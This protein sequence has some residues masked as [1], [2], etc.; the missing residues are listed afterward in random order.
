MW[1]PAPYELVAGLL[2]SS[3]GCVV[4]IED[5]STAGQLVFAVSFFNIDILIL[6]GSPRSS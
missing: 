2:L 1:S 5:F 3:I 6:P 4:L